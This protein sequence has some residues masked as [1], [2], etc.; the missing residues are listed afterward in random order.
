[1]IAVL[2][3]FPRLIDS[4]ESI[5]LAALVQILTS[6]DQDLN[7]RPAVVN[8]RWGWHEFGM[9]VGWPVVFAIILATLLGKGTRESSLK[10]V[11]LFLF[12][13]GLGS[14]DPHA[15]WPFLHHFPIFKSQHVPSRWQYPGLLLLVTLTAAVLERGL[16]RSGAARAWLEVALLVAIAWVAHDIGSVARLPVTHAFASQMPTTPEALGP[17]HT[18]IHLPPELAYM[19]NYVELSLSAEIANIGTIDCSTF[20][21]LNVFVRDSKGRAR[22]MG[23]HGRGDADYK[24]EEYVADGAGQATVEKWTPNQ[25]TVAVHGA[26]PGEHVVLNQNWDTGWSANGSQA[27]NIADQ[28]AA[29][30]HARDETIVFRYRPTSWNVALVTFI[31]TLGGI[32]YA[33]YLVRKVRRASVR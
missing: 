29:P 17:F 9:Y 14:I 33:Y 7:S 8:A 30:L 20:P 10:W 2:A 32:G 3:R 23:A 4:P 6:R 16:R 13:L 1:M 21:G 24:G 26:A 27:M 22:G 11:G 25:V 19:A 12:L 15:P 18:E 31:A 5:D 28:V